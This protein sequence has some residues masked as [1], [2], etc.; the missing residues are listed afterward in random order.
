[1]IDDS[2]VPGSESIQGPCRTETVSHITTG[3][4]SGISRHRFD[5]HSTISSYFSYTKPLNVNQQKR[6]D[7]QL[8]NMI[9]K[10]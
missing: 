2:I 9:V 7:Q 3:R 8:I 4:P 6:V 5:G 10:G 1:M